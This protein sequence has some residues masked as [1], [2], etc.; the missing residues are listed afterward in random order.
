MVSDD[1]RDFVLDQLRRATPAAVTWRAMFG[2]IG[3]YADG[4]FFALMAE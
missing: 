2:G 3:V 4:L 1:Y